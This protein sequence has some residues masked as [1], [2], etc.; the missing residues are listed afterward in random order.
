M[1][2]FINDKKYNIAIKYLL[3]GSAFMCSN[4][5]LKIGQSI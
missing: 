3:I 2:F 4:I 1:F 5:N